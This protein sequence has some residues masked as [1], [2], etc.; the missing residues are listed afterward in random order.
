M[1]GARGLTPAGLLLL[2]LL[3]A[4]ATRPPSG[5]PIEPAAQEAA[6]REIEGFSLT[7]RTAIRAAAENVTAALSWT[8]EGEEGRVRLTGPFGIGSLQVTWT[9]DSLR[10]IGG[11]DQVVEGAEAEA[12]LLEELGFVPPFAA[13]RYWIVGVAAPGE[14]PSERENDE[15]SG[16]LSSLSQQGWRIR[17]REWMRAR[18]PAGTVEVPRNLIVTRDELT[19][20]VVVQRWKL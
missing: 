8:Q 5:P 13:L 17:Y 16:R 4:C 1:S 7:G 12:I 20:R 10:L 11:K 9:P 14:S 6:L 3:T 18:S 15:A 2:L 19:L